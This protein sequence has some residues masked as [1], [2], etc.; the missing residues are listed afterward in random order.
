VT[1]AEL[2]MPR[3]KGYA[4]MKAASMASAS[5]PYT[6]TK[7]DRT[8]ST[9]SI[10]RPRPP[11]P[12][13]RYT[14]PPTA[15]AM[16]HEDAANEE[17]EAE[18]PLVSSNN[19]RNGSRRMYLGSGWDEDNNGSDG[20]SSSCSGT[21]GGSEGGAQRRRRGGRQRSPARSDDGCGGGGEARRM[22]MMEQDHQRFDITEKRK[23]MMG[24]MRQC[25]TQDMNSPGGDGGATYVPPALLEKRH[26]LMTTLKKIQSVNAFASGSAGYYSDSE[27]QHPQ[28]KR[29]TVGFS[30][31][32][33]PKVQKATATRPL[34]R[35]VTEVF[36]SR[37]LEAANHQAVVYSPPTI[38]SSRQRQPQPLSRNNTVADF[39]AA[40]AHT[41]SRN[42]TVAD[43]NSS[44]QYFVD[45]K[46]LA[47]AHHQAAVYSPPTIDT[48]RQRQPQPLSRNNTVADFSAAH[49]QSLSRNATVADFS[50]SEQYAASSLYTHNQDLERFK[51]EFRR[52]SS[53]EGRSADYARQL[54]VGSI[55]YQ[56]II[57]QQLPRDSLSRALTMADRPKS[58][59]P[60][61]GYSAASSTA[62]I[63]AAN[64]A[65]RPRPV[66]RPMMTVA[67]PM[68]S[69]SDE[70]S[71]ESARGRWDALRQH[72][73]QQSLASSASTSA[74]APPYRDTVVT[75]PA[76][77]T[78][79]SMASQSS[80]G[81]GFL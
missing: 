11:A 6:M 44:G 79:F 43:F 13:P 61:Y 46:T 80:E 58:T 53:D 48:S 30:T 12:P 14:S 63:V 52:Q 64:D 59:S 15:T 81:D 77:T 17:R 39:S 38:D 57:Q 31:P 67:D 21:G 24:Q 4:Q 60:N 26:L 72:R 19:D 54:A 65:S 56:D 40:H 47:A 32:E 49:A 70:F 23:H 18:M 29:R 33:N 10:K 25:Q 45:S 3:N 76:L 22:M 69:H 73:H 51:T 41:L 68:S 50:S 36:D 42:A 74:P 1:Y 8:M 62:T 34:A 20:G 35:C 7:A 71:S 55:G 78:I 9:T 5:S 28:A 66:L 27:Q 37:T 75:R 2:T 16:M